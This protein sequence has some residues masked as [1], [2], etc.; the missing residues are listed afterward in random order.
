MIICDTDIMVDVLRGNPG[1]ISW[2]GAN[3]RE[4]IAL[5][6]LVVMELLQGCRNKAEQ[7]LV[8]KTLKTYH[9][10]WPSREAC[11][12]ALR[13]FASHHL[14]HGIGIIDALIAETAVEADAPLC[15]FNQKHYL[16]H[17]KLKTIQP[18]PR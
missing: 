17:P 3:S 1:A 7:N 5:P 14:S 18:Y 4:T 10:L 12:R 8:N 16:P 13:H 6:G 2:L 9:L 11:D 15:T